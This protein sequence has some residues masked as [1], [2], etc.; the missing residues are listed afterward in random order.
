MDND[1]PIWGIEQGSV[2]EPNV[3][4]LSVT[5]LCINVDTFRQRVDIENASHQS[6]TRNGKAVRLRYSLSTEHLKRIKS[7]QEETM[8]KIHC[9]SLVS[10]NAWGQQVFVATQ[11][12]A[13]W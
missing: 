12:T 4:I 11:E 3:E 9:H 8:R 13:K 7:S 10:G 6:S 2:R 5:D 1:I